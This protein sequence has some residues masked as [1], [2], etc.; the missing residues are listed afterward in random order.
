MFPEKR[1]KTAP[2]LSR[3]DVILVHNG[4]HKA[5]QEHRDVP[6]DKNREEEKQSHSDEKGNGNM[7]VLAFSVDKRRGR[8]EKHKKHDEHH[9]AYQA[10]TQTPHEQ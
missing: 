4:N 1:E 3:F 10:E 8:E 5:L 6:D 2:A 9:Q 7:P